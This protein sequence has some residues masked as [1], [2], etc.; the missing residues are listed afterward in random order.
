ML[1]ELSWAAGKIREVAR[2]ISALEVR[3]TIGVDSDRM[4]GLGAV[5]QE[6]KSASL[7]AGAEADWAE[8]IQLTLEEERTSHEN[9]AS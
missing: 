1:R 7:G 6:T 4:T 3:L 9:H 8:P 5:G 2:V